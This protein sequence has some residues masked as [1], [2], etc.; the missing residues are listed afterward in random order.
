MTGEE[1]KCYNWSKCHCCNK[2]VAKEDQRMHEVSTLLT[3]YPDHA[4]PLVTTYYMAC[5][6]CVSKKILL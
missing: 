5:P 3:T 2:E 1:F 6:E 4:E